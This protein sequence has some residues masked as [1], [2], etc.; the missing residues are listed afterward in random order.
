M[1]LT[2]R[3]KNK[4]Y[5]FSA[6]TEGSEN[7]KATIILCHG[8][9][10]GM[11][12]PFMDTL[13]NGLISHNFRVVRFNFPY[14]ESGRKSPGAPLISMLAIQEIVRYVQRAISTPLFLGGKSYGGRMSS[15]AVYE[16]YVDNIEGLVYFGFP[17]HAPGKPSLKRAEHLKEISSPM[18][19]L[20]GTKD[21]LA[22]VG[23]INQLEIANPDS[24]IVFFE[25]ADHSFKVRGKDME[26]TS[27]R[28]AV[29][30][31]EWIN[32]ILNP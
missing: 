19:F 8:A 14:M 4:D 28:L 18:L 24:K 32:Q 25:N 3:Y 11:K 30:T 12:H 10:A 13:A 27:N 7:S 31:S 16:K 6:I 2:F 15:H 26:E 1:N 5:Q 21:K 17:L 29:E 9:G 20:Q 22:E 23:L